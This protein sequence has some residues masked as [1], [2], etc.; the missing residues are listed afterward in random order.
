MPGFLGSTKTKTF[1]HLANMKERCNINEIH[2]H[3]KKYFEPD[4]K[5]QAIKEGFSP[6]NW[7]T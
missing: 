4:T 5:E 3:E 2:I 7:C 1:H 6:C